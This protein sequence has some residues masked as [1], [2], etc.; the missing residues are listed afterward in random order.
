MTTRQL[1]RICAALSNENR[2]EILKSILSANRKEFA[3]DPFCPMA[4]IRDNLKIG[5]P[6]ISHHLKELEN[7]GLIITERNGKYLTARGN[8]EVLNE[9]KGAFGFIWE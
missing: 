8:D 2:L 4:A 6:T 3:C 1:A 5:A 9:L 7:A